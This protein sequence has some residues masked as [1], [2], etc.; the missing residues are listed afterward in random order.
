MNDGEPKGVSLRSHG[1]GIAR[2]LFT[3]YGEERQL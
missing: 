1:A 2:D 3:A